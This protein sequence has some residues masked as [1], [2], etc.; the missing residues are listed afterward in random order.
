[1][2][3][4]KSSNYLGDMSNDASKSRRERNRE[5]QQQFR[6]RRQAAE[7]ARLQRL[8]RLEGVIERMST[9]IVG[10]ADKM[11][12]EDVLKQYPALAADTQD[13]IASVLA[14][15][16]EAGDPEEKSAAEP[17][18]GT[19]PN[20]VEEE[21]RRSDLG[22]S[23]DQPVSSDIPTFSLPPNDQNINFINESSPQYH[24]FISYPSR[25]YP[26]S[27]IGEVPYLPPSMLPPSIGLLPWNT[28]KPLSPTS[29]THQLTHTCFNVGFLL[30]TK[31]PDSPVPLAD[32]VRV[33][34]STLRS[35]ERH[36]MTTRI[37]WFMGPG[38]NDMKFFALMPY[39]GQWLDKGYTASELTKTTNKPTIPF[40]SVLGV[41]RQLAAMGAHLVAKDT[42]ELEI[43]STMDKK[44]P[45]PLQPLQPESWS[46]VNIFPPDVLQPKSKPTS[47]RVS[48]SLL[49]KNL[50]E[51]SVCLN[52]G[53]GFPRKR[54]G[55]AIMDS[56]VRDKGRVL[57]G[58]VCV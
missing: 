38:R 30:L 50:S 46:F 45:K 3:Q 31:S 25:T 41:E 23:D 49:V 6:K 28:S 13:V 4:T 37:T 54:L 53:P 15:A 19:T 55:R 56:V 7:A 11:L 24:H 14:L 35:D 9:V 12:Q 48:I 47:I 57:P 18:E 20:F 26:D 52:G 33:F 39:G 16:N 51:I 42:L 21:P 8:K 34:G 2:P 27:A 58:V 44:E 10:Y 43:D 17:I 36:E 29:F 1:M 32:E 22:T 40:Y 5:A